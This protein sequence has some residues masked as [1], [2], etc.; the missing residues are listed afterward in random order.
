MWE[1][2]VRLE[3]VKEENGP[4]TSIN[5]DYQDEG[6]M[7]IRISSPQPHTVVIETGKWDLVG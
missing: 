1:G 5:L 2:K 7:G 3:V 6:Y 4:I